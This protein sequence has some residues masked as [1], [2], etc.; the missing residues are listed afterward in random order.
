MKLE[1]LNPHWKKNFLYN[2]PKKRFVFNEIIKFIKERFIIAIT[3]IRR[4]GKTTI[5]KQL[6]NFLIN[7]D[8]P[9]EN[10]LFYSFED[11]KNINEVIEEYIKFKRIDITKDKIYFLFDEIQFINNWQGIVK[12]YYDIYSNI[13]FIVSGSSSLFLKKDIES[14]SGRIIEFHLPVLNFQEYLLFKE[15]KLEDILNYEIE[16]EFLSYLKEQFI[17]IIGKDDDIKN[18]YYSSIIKKS[19]YEDIPKIYS[20][21]YPDLLEKIFNI[22]LS[23]P[24]IYLDYKSLGNDLKINE[25]TI[26]NYVFY[27]ENSYLIK[28]VYN[29]SKNRLTSEKK[30]KRGYVFATSFLFLN[31]YFEISKI[32][33]NFFVVNFFNAKF[34]WRDP[35]KHEID[36][37]AQNEIPIE[38]KF[39]N[40]I[41]KKD[42]KNLLIFMKRFNVNKGILISKL[43]KNFTI[44]GYLIESKHYIDIV[45]NP[46]ININQNLNQ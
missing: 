16:K 24:G 42:I 19:I 43:N 21:E 12:Q 6:I 38:I 22:I 2:F 37:I 15:I 28:K 17:E 23:N 35:Y 45:L 10:I 7:N 9:R 40:K 3:G 26:S 1:I 8:I 27:L 31:E 33:E 5:L 18:I 4:T 39:K 32:I 41:N 44:N 25:K 20:I 14:L 29:F 11:L 13:K 34:F 36:I 46:H 30:L